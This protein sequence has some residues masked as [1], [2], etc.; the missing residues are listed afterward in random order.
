MMNNLRNKDEITSLELLKE[1]NK[2]RELEYNYKVENNLE[3]GKVE[4]KNG[5]YTEL[6]HNDLLKIIRDEFE[7]EITQ[8]KI[9]LSEYK[10]NTGK[11]NQMYILTLSQAKQLFSRESKYVRKKMIK[12]I[13]KLEQEI[14]K[15]KE[16][17]IK[18]LLQMQLE[19]IEKIE[20]L[21]LENNEKQKVIEEKGNIISEQK[22]KAEFYDK[23]TESED[24]FDFKKV[25]KIINVKGLGRN[26]LIALL[27]EQKILDYSNTPYQR[28]VT[29]GY[30]KVVEKNYIDFF[31]NTRISTKTVVFQKGIDFILRLLKRLGYLGDDKQ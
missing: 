13:E 14:K 1:I 19:S 29:Q 5:R 3:L 30:F 23:V 25:A 28:Y 20:R 21:E 7:E 16:Y 8:G 17:T 31:G 27:R 12:Y 6:K 10:D 18:E 2:L 24:M 26:N 9:S 11:K 22:P 15:P 4:L